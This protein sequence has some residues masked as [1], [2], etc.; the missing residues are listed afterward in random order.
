MDTQHLIISYID[1]FPLE[2]FER[3]RSDVEIPR[4]KLLLEPRPQEVFAGI[5]WL[6]PTAV[7]VYIAKSYF[8]SF[9]KEMGKDHYVL[10]KSAIDKLGRKILGREAPRIGIIHTKGKI[11]QES[12]KYS[13]AF[14]VIAEVEAHVRVKLLFDVSLSEG[15]YAYAL[16]EFLNWLEHLQSGVSS[17]ASLKG[18]SDIR[19]ISGTVLIVFNKEEKRLE[20]IDPLRK[21]YKDA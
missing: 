18:F 7:V 2:S 15:D 12:P 5:E 20:V 17:L 13:L 10:F 8:E 9:L 14:S 11:D 19:T 16:Q 3:F 21:R 1:T 4:L 6:L